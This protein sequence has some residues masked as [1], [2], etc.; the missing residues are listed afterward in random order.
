ID[1]A[2]PS[3]SGVV[4]LD[5]L[6]RQDVVDMALWVLRRCV[7]G[8]NGS[9]GFV[10]K[11][12]QNLVRYSLS[13]QNP[14]PFPSSFPST[15]SFFT[16]TITSG[17]PT[18]ALQ[19]GNFDPA[20][21]LTVA[22]YADFLVTNSPNAPSS[23]TANLLAK[24]EAWTS[25]AEQMRPG[26]DVPWWASGN[27]AKDEVMMY[28]CDAAL[29]GNPSEI[30]CTQ[31]EWQQLGSGSSSGLDTVTVGPGRVEFFH[32]SSNRVGYADEC[33]CGKSCVAGSWGQSVLWFTYY[34]KGDG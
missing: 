8:A 33:V 5:N 29:L 31:I 24:A 28:K 30:D 32:Q 21:P 16:L 22:N 1:V 9:G 15:T 10:T 34:S 4:N 19:P 26:G 7:M 17:P 23:V 12:L 20:I 11:L 14:T 3:P 2:G 18:M 25:Q 6:R 13:D 27:A